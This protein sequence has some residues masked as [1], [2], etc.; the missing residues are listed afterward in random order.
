MNAITQAESIAL[1]KADQNRLL[2][3]TEI[4]GCSPKTMLKFV[5]QDGFEALAAEADAQTRGTVPHDE[6]MRGSHRIIETARARKR[7]KTHKHAA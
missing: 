5:L 3:L 2:H 1:T 6:V 7:E 4:A